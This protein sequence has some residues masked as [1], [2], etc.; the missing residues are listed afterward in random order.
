MKK[1]A[2]TIQFIPYSQI[3]HLKSEARIKKLIHLVKEEKIILLEGS[4]K[5]EEESLLIQKTMESINE[6]FT[7]IEISPLI[8]K[9]ETTKFLEKIKNKII[10][11]LLGSRRGL[12]IIGPA[13]IVKEIKKDPN[14]IQL[15]TQI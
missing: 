11:L 15:Y 2:L 4:L 3:E 9:D 10:D 6:E 5:P 12:T 14:K 13:N 1:K 7:G 8:I